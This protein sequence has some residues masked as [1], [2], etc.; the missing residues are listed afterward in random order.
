MEGDVAWGEFRKWIGN[1]ERVF[2]WSDT[3]REF[4]RSKGGLSNPRFWN[5]VGVTGTKISSGANGFRFK[6]ENEEFSS[7]APTSSSK[8]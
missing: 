6:T 3:A 1:R 7:L 5:R 8:V 2:D 4:Y